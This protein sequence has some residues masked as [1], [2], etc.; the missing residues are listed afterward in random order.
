MKLTVNR[1][2]SQWVRYRV[3]KN[4]EFLVTPKIHSRLMLKNSAKAK[5]MANSKLTKP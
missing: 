3:R 4:G 1:Y 2:W 5:S